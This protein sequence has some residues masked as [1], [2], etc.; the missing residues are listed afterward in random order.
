MHAD[1]SLNLDLIGRQAE[2]LAAHGVAG[3]F[4]CG[5]TGEGLSLTTDE[6]FEVAEQ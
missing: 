4:I 1:G 5:T 3:A 2:A 6:R